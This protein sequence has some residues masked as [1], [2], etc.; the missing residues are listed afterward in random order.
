MKNTAYL[1]NYTS[2]SG[3]TVV[4]STHRFRFIANLVLKLQEWINPSRD[5]LGISSVPTNPI[6]ILAAFEQRD[7]IIEQRDAAEAALAEIDAMGRKHHPAV[8]ILWG[9][10]SRGDEGGWVWVHDTQAD[11]PVPDH[12]VEPLERI[13]A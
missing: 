12:L 3:N 10:V 13:L 1:V 8:E 5:D 11:A 2:A 6:E 4:V 9:L 7:Q